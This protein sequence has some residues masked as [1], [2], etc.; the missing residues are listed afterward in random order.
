MTVK[1][2][3]SLLLPLRCAGVYVIGTAMKL[4]DKLGFGEATESA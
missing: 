3:V 1:V 4:E 2:V